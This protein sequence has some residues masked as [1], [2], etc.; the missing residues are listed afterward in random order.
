V[1]CSDQE[2][3]VTKDFS[4]NCVWCA[5]S[6]KRIVEPLFFESTVDGTVCRELIQQDG[7]TCHTSNETMDMLQDFFGDRLIS[8]NLW[9]PRSPDLSIPEFFLRG[10]LK[11]KVYEDNPHTIDD[12]KIVITQRIQEVIPRPLKCVSKMRKRFQLLLPRKGRTF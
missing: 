3:E 5:V 7:A 1:G 11:N 2:N 4:K 12:L 9:S 6:R 8:K 10:Y